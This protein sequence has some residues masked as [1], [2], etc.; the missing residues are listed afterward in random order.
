MLVFLEC[1]KNLDGIF[2][3]DIAFV[4]EPMLKWTIAEG[5]VFDGSSVRDQPNDDD[6]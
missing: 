6:S 1:E 5:T 2:V 3:T 4:F